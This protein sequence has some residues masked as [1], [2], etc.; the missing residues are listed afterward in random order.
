M[1]EAETF[2]LQ[3]HETRNPICTTSN[4]PT[5]N[6][7]RAGGKKLEIGAI[8][9]TLFQEERKEKNCLRNHK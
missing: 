6:T 4:K 2:F 1:E 7:D 9:T 3:P 8:Y 5:G